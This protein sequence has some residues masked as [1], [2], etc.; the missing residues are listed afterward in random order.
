M[1]TESKVEAVFTII[2]QGN[3]RA[4]WRQVGVGF[5]NRDSSIN[6]VLDALPTNGKLHDDDGPIIHA[7]TRAQAIEDGVLVD[8]T[9]TA[10]EAGFTL[11]V[12]LT[13]RVW[14]EI[15]TPPEAA[16][17][18]G[19]SESGRLW[20]VLH[21]TRFAIARSQA[22]VSE[23]AVQ[24][25]VADGSRHNHTVTL[26]AHCGPGDEGEPVITIMWPEED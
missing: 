20:D 2:E 23:L 21:M 5:V 14:A 17:S 8:D 6:L 15:V 19:Q 10:R 1:F 3:N 26:K 16:R 4:I 11:P 22:G 9:D 7:Y 25:I 13:A 24:L 12:A 18:Y